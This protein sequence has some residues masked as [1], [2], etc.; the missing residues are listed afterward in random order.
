[1]PTLIQ[2][3]SLTFTGAGPHSLAFASAGTNP[4]FYIVTLSMDEEAQTATC[5]DNRNGSYTADVTVSGGSGAGSGRCYSFSVQNTSAAIATVTVTL[6]AASEGVLQIYEF[7]GVATASP[8]NTSNT[9]SGIGTSRSVSITTTTNNCVVVAQGTLYPG[10]EATADA[11]F[12]SAFGE[13]ATGAAYH[14]GEYRAD[15]G[16]AGGMTL[17]LGEIGSSD[18]WTMVVA[19]YKAAGGAPVVSPLFYPRRV[20]FEV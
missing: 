1:M 3:T 19:A 7:S 20:F 12:T 2:E 5:A 13:V 4:S 16:A 10:V 11:G 8:L 14:F 6:S 9:G 15:A 17:T 18:S